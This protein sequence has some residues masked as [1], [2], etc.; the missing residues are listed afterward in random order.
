[1]FIV[2]DLEL[3]GYSLLIS[4]GF[5]L[6]AVLGLMLSR[7]TKQ[8]K[9][10]EIK[11]VWWTPSPYIIGFYLLIAYVFLGFGY[12]LLR[13]ADTTF[14][15]IKLPA[16]LYLF[17]W[18]V[19]ALRGYAGYASQLLGIYWLLIC[20]AYVLGTMI[21]VGIYSYW[22]PAVMILP[23]FALLVTGILV[24]LAYRVRSTKNN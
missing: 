4:G 5:Y 14:D 22:L 12:W 9:S 23:L 24:E 18:V 2:S 13:R 1:M 15:N 19:V 16:L 11:V 21:A 10:N 17:L 3:L 7:A 8:P 20:V 6:L